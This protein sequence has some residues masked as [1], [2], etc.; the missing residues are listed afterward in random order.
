MVA[1]H[2]CIVTNEETLETRMDELRIA[3]K[4]QNYPVDII[5]KGTEK[6][7]TTKK[8]SHYGMYMV[9]HISEFGSK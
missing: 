5:E 3:L 2:Y 8:T 7:K 4:L 9:Y 6:K 1:L